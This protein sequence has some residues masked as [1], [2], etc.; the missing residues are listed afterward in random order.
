MG[1]ASGAGARLY[2]LSAGKRPARE[3][4][5]L[6]RDPYQLKNVAEDPAYRGTLESLDR[7]LQNELAAT[8]DPRGAG[9]GDEFDSYI[10]YQGRQ[11]RLGR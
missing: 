4:Y 8:A 10:W 6:T 7:Q 5:D 9:H 2:E 3:L 11:Q 1:R